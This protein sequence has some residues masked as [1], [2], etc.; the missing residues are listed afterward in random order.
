MPELEYSQTPLYVQ[1]YTELK[2]AIDEGDLKP[3][4]RFPT[5]SELAQRNDERKLSGTLPRTRILCQ[6][7]KNVSSVKR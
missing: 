3:G 6:P 7:E 1:L 5:E 4:E 2:R